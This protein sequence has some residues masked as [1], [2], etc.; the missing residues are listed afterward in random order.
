MTE[1]SFDVKLWQIRKLRTASPRWQLRWRVGASKSPFSR[2]FTAY[3]LAEGF[4]DQLRTAMRNGE[5]FCTQTGLPPSVLRQR[6]PV[7]EPD[8]SWFA[9]ARDFMDYKWPRV[10]ASNR[11]SLA[12]VLC[13]ATCALLPKR[14]DRPEEP[15]LRKALRRWA[16]TAGK[17]RNGVKVPGDISVVLEWAERH[18]P[19][20]AKVAE[21]EG[22][23]ELLDAMAVT[24]SGDPA[25]SNYFYRRRA[26]LYN[27]FKYAVV[28]KHLAANPLAAQDLGWEKPDRLEID[29]TL[30]PRSVGNTAHVEAMLTAVSYVGRVRGPRLV[31]FYACVYYAMMRPSEVIDLKRSQCLLPDAGWGLLT[32]EGAAPDVGKAWTDTGT[33]HDVRG[34]KRRSAKATRP[35][36][37]PPRLVAL[38]KEHIAQF[39]T[40]A[41]G[42]LFRTATGNRI[43]SDAIQKTWKL[44]RDYGLAWADRDTLRLKRVYD[45]RHSGISLRRTAGVPARQVAEWAGHSV[46]VLERI[47]S[48]VLEGYDDRWTTQMD[49]FF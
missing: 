1:T 19:A 5:A 3:E 9:H 43:G 40:A 35:I 34:L 8:V 47:Y 15:V 23:R 44:A 14:T 48:K 37:I 29:H 7:E 4:R 21:A 6:T 42:R 46:E 22:T 13:D 33:C 12:S 18:S 30:D 32:L 10:A 39:G 36:P 2:T 49:N 11:S 16:F 41:D 45:L 17:S 28:R 38:L 26:V 25:S 20:L 27:V 24:L 31:A